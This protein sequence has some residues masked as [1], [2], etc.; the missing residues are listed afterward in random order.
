[1][2]TVEPAAGRRF[3][4]AVVGL[5]PILQSR[6]ARLLGP[7]AQ[8]SAV[9]AVEEL[10]RNRG[11][12]E[13][14]VVVL[15]PSFADPAAL[16]EAI[17]VVSTQPAMAAVLVVEEL[18]TQLLQRAMR[19]GVSDVVTY[20]SDPADLDE[21]ITRAA[22]NLSARAPLAGGG[23]GDPGFE[24]TVVTVFSPKGGSGKS[25]I[26]CNLAAVL[27]QRS[28]HPV[29]IV[30][31]DL[32]FGDVAVMLK[33][34]PQH[35]IVD[36]VSAMHRL[37][38]DL[39][40]SLLAVHG[41]S[42]LHVL[43]A[44]RE[45]AFGDQVTPT[46]MHRIVDLL[47]GFC[48]HIVIDTPAQFS[49]VALHLIEESDELVLVAGMDVPSIKNMKIGLQTL[50]LLGTPSSKLRL[51]LNRANAKV[52][53]DVA[54]VE[55]TLHLKAEALVPSDITVPQSVNKGTPAVIT[56]ARSGFARSIFAFADVLAP[57]V[58]KRRRKG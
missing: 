7:R 8:V 50:K 2:T 30:D 36:A 4:L 34:T 20:G 44:P 56:S 25:A 29:A 27:A 21:A 35:T 9:G 23:D 54:E 26:A 17:G 47:R 53:L 46:D 57:D 38:A 33:L 22:A 39:L 11:R 1:M 15:G 19:A 43:A 49:D 32:Q 42:G 58:G 5:E 16:D 28:E 18:S 14:T 6:I 45:P 24:S 12:N 40:R 3:Q 10:K 51:V 55:K 13:P 31:A 48:S 41:P 52:G 37:D